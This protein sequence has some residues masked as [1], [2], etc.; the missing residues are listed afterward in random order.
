MYINGRKGCVWKPYCEDKC[1]MEDWMICLTDKIQAVIYRYIIYSSGIL[2]IRYKPTLMACC[3]TMDI[4]YN[5]RYIIFI[6]FFMHL[7]NYQYTE[8]Y[9]YLIS[10]PPYCVYSAIIR[11]YFCTLIVL[12]LDFKIITAQKLRFT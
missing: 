4:M 11:R 6:E 1:Y 3:R 7:F 10:W 12:R 5:L 2:C 8:D 9:F